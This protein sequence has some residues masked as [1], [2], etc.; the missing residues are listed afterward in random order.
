MTHDEGI[1][2]R[3]GEEHT[4]SEEEHSGVRGKRACASADIH[5]IKR[6]DHETVEEHKADTGNYGEDYTL[7]RSLLTDG[8]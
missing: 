8:R 1:E 6:L 2:N 4:E 3:S 7:G 5:G